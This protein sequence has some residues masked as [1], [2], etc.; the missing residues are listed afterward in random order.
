MWL[1]NVDWI[2]K[3]MD[4]KKSIFIWLIIE[5]EWGKAELQIK[6]IEEEWMAWEESEDWDY[7]MDAWYRVHYRVGGTKDDFLG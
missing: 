4:R 5:R 3:Y 2:E 7:D 6:Y 1:L